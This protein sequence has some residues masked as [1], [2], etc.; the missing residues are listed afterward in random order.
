[1]N[2]GSYKIFAAASARSLGDELARLLGQPLGRLYSTR[3][4]DGEV[5]SR[6]D[7][8]IR[9]ETVVLVG[10]VNMPYNN[11]FEF[12]TAADAA[13]RASASEI[14]AVLPYL[15]HSRQERRD[16]MRTGVISRMVAD[17][18]QLSGVDRLITIDLHSP[19]IEGFYKIP[20]DHISMSS[21]FLGDIR[22]RFD[23]EN[24]LLCSPDFGGL[25]RIRAYKQALNCEM[26]VIHKERL[27]HNQVSSMEVIGTPT[28]KDVILIDDL[29][30][31]GG[32]LCKAAEILLEQGARSVTAYCTHGVLSGEASATIEQSL[33]KELVIANTIPGNTYGAKVRVISC[34]P[35]LAK[36]LE[37]LLH[38]QS[39]EG[40]NKL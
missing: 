7:E 14:L 29:I 32:T 24:T 25:K 6:F 26:A 34:A 11:L 10:Q 3:F 36:A 28:D 40:L 12:F 39:L 1:M 35:I 33:L 23:M 21:V 20:I 31:T 38:H 15:P 22:Q 17:F 2:T 5:F 16:G 4:S 8:T 37:A 13:R 27:K 18:I 9:G 19:A 30:D